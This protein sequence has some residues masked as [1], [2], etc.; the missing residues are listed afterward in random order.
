[1]VITRELILNNLETWEK[2]EKSAQETWEWAQAHFR[3]GTVDYNDWEDGNSAAKEVL[4]YLDSLDMNLIIV[5]DVPI[6]A[7]FLKSPLGNFNEA[8]DKWQERLD[9]ID[10]RKRQKDLRVDPIYERFCE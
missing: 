3:Q 9:A 10:Y 5:E 6:H 2:G 7:D 4:G 8:Y 1:M